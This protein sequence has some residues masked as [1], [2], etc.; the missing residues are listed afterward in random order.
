[1]NFQVKTDIGWKINMLH[2]IIIYCEEVHWN[3]LISTFQSSIRWNIIA[4]IIWY[5]NQS[6]T[7]NSHNL[8]Q[9]QLKNYFYLFH[10]FGCCLNKVQDELLLKWQSFLYF[11]RMTNYSNAL[12]HK[13]IE[14][15]IK[16]WHFVFF[17][18]DHSNK[19][20]QIGLTV[21]N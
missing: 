16:E 1:M 5:M 10:Q 6:M 2:I 7:L 18:F 11:R 9:K 15:H 13:S 20:Q 12:L 3:P 19:R 8:L 4:S 17:V 14:R 21:K